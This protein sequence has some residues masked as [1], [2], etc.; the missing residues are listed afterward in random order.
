MFLSSR[1]KDSSVSVTLKV[2]EHIQ[3]PSYSGRL[4]YNMTAGQLPFK[5]QSEFIQQLKSQLNFLKSY[6]YSPLGG[7]EE[8]KT[9]LI[10]WTAHKRE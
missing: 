2:N 8:L 7:F 1:V 3:K 4:I 9:K 5:P 6:Q 10:K